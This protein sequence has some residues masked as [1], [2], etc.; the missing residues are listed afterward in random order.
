MPDAETGRRP[1]DVCPVVVPRTQTGIDPKRQLTAGKQRPKCVDLCNRAG[2]EQ[3]APV[4]QF[5][6]IVR[7]LLRCELNS[8]GGNT[9]AERA[10]DLIAAAGI[11]M[12][13]GIGQ[14][15]DHCA[16]WTSLHRISGRQAESIGKAK[17]Q[18]GL[19]LQRPLIIYKNRCPKLTMDK[20]CFFFSK[21]RD[22]FH[23]CSLLCHALSVL[24]VRL[25]G[26]RQ[27]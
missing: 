6:Q 8:F 11:N 21:K 25:Q 20:T 16:C 17:Y 27:R 24:H 9:G 13:T 5:L 3:D 26:Q 22:R 1:A 15:L 23:T 2:I 7:H 18:A 4:H 14:H 19:M 10:L 12:Q